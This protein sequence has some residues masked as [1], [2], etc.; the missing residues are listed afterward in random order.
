MANVLQLFDSFNQGGT[1]WQTVQLTRLLHE[2]GKHRIFL[3]SLSNEGPLRAEVE[4]LGFHDIPSFP[5]QNF[6]NVNAVKQL[7]RLASLMRKNKIDLVH[8]HDFYTNIFGTAAAKLAGV[9]AR[10]ASRRE[11]EGIRSPAKRWL[12]RRAF[13]AASAVVANAESIRTQLIAEGLSPEKV[14]TIH[15]GLDINHVAPT[16]EARPIELLQSFRLPNS[17]RFVTI[18]ANMRHVM[19]DQ[20]TFL[21]AAQ[22]TRAAVPDSSFILAGEGEQMPLLQQLAVDLGLEDHA[23]FIGRC[24]RIADLLAISH[25]GVL[26][27]KGVEGFSNSILEYMAAGLPVVATD[28]GGAREAVIDGETGYIVKPEDFETMAARLISLLSKAG[29]GWAM[30]ERGRKRVLE[31]FSCEAQLA[32]VE[33]LYE[34]LLSR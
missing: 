23:F 4:R 19:K 31:Q 26:S 13:N 34:R 20:A 1:E 29:G 32:R 28:V 25:V 6:Y 7:S 33:Q 9:R 8:A 14:V 15:N 22:L 3:A 21:R 11:T 2:S 24:N 27:S 16:P 12:E 18:V 5:L 30:G 10:I 17:R